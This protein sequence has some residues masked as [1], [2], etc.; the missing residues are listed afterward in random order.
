[1]KETKQGKCTI[2]EYEE[3]ERDDIED[4]KK[5]AKVVLTLDIFV[6]QNGSIGAH[7]H[8]LSDK[9]TK[10]FQKA[11]KKMDMAIILS[12]EGIKGFSYKRL[13]FAQEAEA[14]IDEFKKQLEEHVIEEKKKESVH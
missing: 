8:G 6:N 9:E 12:E 14:Y 7:S 5:K 3:G 1:M 2:M 11:F 4:I 10:F 13:Q